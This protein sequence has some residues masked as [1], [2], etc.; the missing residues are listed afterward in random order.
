MSTLDYVKENASTFG[1]KKIDRI[2]WRQANELRNNE[3]KFTKAAIL[4]RKILGINKFV[5]NNEYYIL[6]TIRELYARTSITR[7]GRNYESN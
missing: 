3:A 2:L 1:Q 4:E 5:K 7:T 6:E